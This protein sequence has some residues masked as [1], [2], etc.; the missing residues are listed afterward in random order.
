MR[1][2]VLGAAITAAMLVTGHANAEDAKLKASLME[3]RGT[4]VAMVKDPTKRDASQQA[5]VKSS[6]DAFTKMLATATP[7]AGKEAAFKDLSETWAAY[8]QT[9]EAEVVPDILAGKQA[10]ADKLVSGVQKQRYEKML[11]I[12]SAM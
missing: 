6:A 11:G 8:K 4:L 2:F 3:A 7:P 12:I 1:K 5:M 10:E 9:R